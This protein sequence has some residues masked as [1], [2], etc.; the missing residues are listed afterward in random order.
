MAEG[1]RAS[2]RFACR[3][4]F[5]D[6]RLRDWIAQQPD[7]ELGPCAWCGT[8]RARLIPLEELGGHF[9]VA[10]RMYSENVGEIALFAGEGEAIGY[11]FHDDWATFSNA[12][13]EAGQVDELCVAILK[14]GLHPKDDVDEPDYDGLF[15][16]SHPLERSVDEDWEER[17]GE[18]LSPPPAPI[19]SDEIAEHPELADI[20]I[21]YVPDRLEYIIEEMGRE[22]EAGESLYRARIHDER[23][24]TERFAPHEVSAPP[25]DKAKAGRANRPNEPML[26]VASD[27]RTA[28]SEVR[29][30]K[31]A[32]VAL[33]RMVL[34]KKVRILNLTDFEAIT[35][36]FFEE[37]IGWKVEARN[38]LWRLREDMKR[39]VMPH[40]A[41]R[42]YQPTQYAAELIRNAGFDGIA[43]PSAMGP[44]I[45][46][47]LFDPA[48]GEVTEVGY[49]RIQEVVYGFER[50]E[51]A[52]IRLDEFPYD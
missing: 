8:R 3:S 22:F 33:A 28:I 17:V 42:Q 2:R 6:E 26:Y 40:L 23:E 49:V 35:S 47:V 11:L 21:D 29:P 10:A 1:R 41:D 9:R 51:A 45:N 7:L 13:E 20:D 18:L 16:R 46:I 50:D 39:P 24:R 48:V 43:Y 12:I 38:L 31:G 37:N 44:G 52:K 27:E 36:P 5:R 32:P 14:A 15:F 34:T 25:A 19:T 4:C 30:W